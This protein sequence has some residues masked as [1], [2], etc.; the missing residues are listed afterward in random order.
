MAISNLHPWPGTRQEYEAQR[1]ALFKR[2]EGNEAAPYYDTADERHPTVGIGFN[3]DV[4][5]VRDLVFIAMGIP[6]HKWAALEA[7]IADRSILNAADPDSTLQS[8]LSCAYEGH[9]T[10][11]LPFD[12]GFIPVVPPHPNRA[13]PWRPKKALNRRRNEIERSSR[14]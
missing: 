7:I 2:F 13:E 8:R 12:L 1:L 6:G 3:L 5:G 11:Q 10:R 4:P 14:D 9:E